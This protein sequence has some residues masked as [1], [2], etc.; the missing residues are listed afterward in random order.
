[1]AFEGLLPEPHN[2]NILH[3]LFVCAHW[4]GLAKLCMHTDQTLKILDDVMTEISAEFCTFTN[5]TC[6]AFDTHKLPHKT[7]SHKRC[8]MNKTNG[9]NGSV[10]SAPEPST[11]IS[12][13]ATNET[14][15]KK[16][17]LQI[18]K[19]HCLGDYLNTIR[20]YGTCDSY[21]TETVRMHLQR[22]GLC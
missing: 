1:V 18:Y 15:P 8:K 20:R 3:L 17:N 13:G 10:D 11:D 22:N 21:L 14:L 19:Y 5:N 9:K 7:A 12:L 2:S 6:S 16:F 4:H